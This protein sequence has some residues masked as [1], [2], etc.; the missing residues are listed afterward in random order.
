MEITQVKT[1]VLAVRMCDSVVCLWLD[2]QRLN[3]NIIALDRTG[4]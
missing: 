3:F 2:D 4:G 1:A